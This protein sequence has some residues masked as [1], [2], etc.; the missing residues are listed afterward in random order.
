MF[1]EFPRTISCAPSVGPEMGSIGLRAGEIYSASSCRLEFSCSG[2]IDPHA[3][4]ITMYHGTNPN[5]TLL[6]FGSERSPRWGNN[7]SF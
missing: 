5:Y 7:L 2:P 6:C 3:V 4:E 1:V